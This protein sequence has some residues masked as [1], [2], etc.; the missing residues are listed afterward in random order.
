MSNDQPGE[1]L[2]DDTTGDVPYPPDRLQGAEAYGTTPVEEAAGEPLAERVARE[3]PDEIPP[4][5][6]DVVLVAPDEGVH[7]D[8]EGAEVA[9][10]VPSG[11]PQPWSSD[12]S[13]GEVVQEQEGARPA[14]EAA[15]HVDPESP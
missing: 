1:R 7:T 10:A 13:T 15:V 12:R 4:P 14:E 5:D 8:T 3:E 2:D 6:D 11:D 9:A